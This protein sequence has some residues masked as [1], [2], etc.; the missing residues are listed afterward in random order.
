M[1][2]QSPDASHSLPAIYGHPSVGRQ[3]VTREVE[4]LLVPLPIP[5][6][7]NSRLGKDQ[8]THRIVYSRNLRQFER[9][10]TYNLGR[11][12]VLLTIFDN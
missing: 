9:Y 8:R 1:L 10:W 11:C 2:R 12:D 3:V 5:T 7:Y 6:G 4:R